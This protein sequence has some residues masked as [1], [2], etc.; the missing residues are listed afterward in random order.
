MRDDLRS[1]A[2]DRAGQP[3]AAALA[4]RLETIA[5]EAERLF[6]GMD[7]GFLYDGERHLFAIGFQAAAGMLDESYY[8]LLASEARLTSLIAIA[9]SDVGSEH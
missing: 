8:D 7:F 6:E 9:K 3:E 4:R 1:H 2:R 5:R